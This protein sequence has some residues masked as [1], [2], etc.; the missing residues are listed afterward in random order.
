M[1]LLGYSLMNRAYCGFY[2]G[3]HNYYEFLT[4]WL[5]ISTVRY[6]LTL[7]TASVPG[8]FLVNQ[9]FLFCALP[10]IIASL[11]TVYQKVAWKKSLSA[12]KPPIE[13]LH[14]KVFIYLSCGRSETSLKHAWWYR[15]PLQDSIH[16]I[17][18][19]CQMSFNFRSQG[20]P[21]F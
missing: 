3:I 8:S 6:K 13:L 4:L 9:F 14:N 18:C 10:S 12:I 1:C 11:V 20:M 19:T 21:V 16:K 5:A 17:L 15:P 2:V 7:K